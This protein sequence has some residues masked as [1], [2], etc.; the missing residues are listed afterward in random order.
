MELRRS[1][2]AAKGSANCHLDRLG[3][4]SSGPRASE[5][6]TNLV[7]GILCKSEKLNLGD[8]FQSS[9][10][11]TKR[12]AD[13]S[14]LGERGVDHTVRTKELLQAIGGPKHTAQVTDVLAEQHHRRVTLHL[15]T[16]CIVYG[17]DHGHLCHQS[18]SPSPNAR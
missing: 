15:E 10:G 17:V 2:I 9:D 13:D 16:Q 14:A 3:A 5:L 6:L 11:E 7:E 18:S 12:S 4:A 8:G 1:H